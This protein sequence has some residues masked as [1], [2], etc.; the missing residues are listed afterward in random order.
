MRSNILDQLPLNADYAGWAVVW[1]YAVSR[2][3]VAGSHQSENLWRLE[4]E[5][6]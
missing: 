2:R 6:W 5:L 1:F 4:Q 3:S